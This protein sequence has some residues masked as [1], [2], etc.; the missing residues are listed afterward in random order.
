MDQETTYPLLRDCLSSETNQL[1]ITKLNSLSITDWELLVQLAVKQD[2]AAL[3]YYR[4]KNSLPHLHFPETLRH[5]LQTT[6]FAAVLQNTRLYNELAKIIQ[7]LHQEGIPV[8]VLK[9]ADLAKNVYNNIALRTM[10]DIDILVRKTD[11]VTT[12]EALRKIGYYQSEGEI[13]QHYHLPPFFKEGAIPIEVHWHIERPF[14]PFTIDIEELWKRTRPTTIAENEVLVLSPED[15]LLHLCV[16][17]AFHHLFQIGLRSLY[18]IA[19]VIHRYQDKME[20][21][22]V[23][24]RTQ[25]WGAN[26]SVYLAL[27]LAETLVGAAVPSEVLDTLK[28]NNCD[29]QIITWAKAQLVHEF[30]ESVLP[31]IALIKCWKSKHILETINIL[32]QRI[33][34]PREE[35]ARM[36]SISPDWP[37][38]YFYYWIRLKDLLVWHSRT[39]WRLA[40]RNKK[41]VTQVELT[42]WLSR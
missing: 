11:L 15:L 30:N 33:F 25:Q 23:C 20:W 35:I 34:L 1:K 22:V 40:R 38:I 37:Q 18:D 31:P 39:I 42:E 8:I 7:A 3:L 5:T 14:N 26:N 17:A 12:D 28:P 9:G 41:M 10:S 16:H 6:Y 27:Y 32:C 21:E 13:A 24:W 2:L 36:Y 4:L 29:P 19:E